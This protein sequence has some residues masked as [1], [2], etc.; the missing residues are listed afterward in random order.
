MCIEK[1]NHALKKSLDGI[2][3]PSFT[4]NLSNSGFTAITTS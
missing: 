3:A 1:T 4:K 2:R